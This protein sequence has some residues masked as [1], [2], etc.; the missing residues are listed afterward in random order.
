MEYPES[1]QE[2]AG[3]HYARGLHGHDHKRNGVRVQLGQR[4][5]EHQF[6]HQ[7]IFGSSPNELGE[8]P[9]LN[10]SRG[11]DFLLFY[12]IININDRVFYSL[13]KI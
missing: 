2:G 13:F 7:I 10:I 11:Y 3:G 12:K 1:Q 5:D 4:D 9:F 8:A 6:Y